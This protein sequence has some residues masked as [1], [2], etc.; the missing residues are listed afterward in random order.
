ML[1]SQGQEGWGPGREARHTNTGEKNVFPHSA[2]GPPLQSSAG[3]WLGLQ[4]LPS[5]FPTGLQAQRPVSV[6]AFPSP[7]PLGVGV[8][9]RGWPGSPSQASCYRTFR[10]QH[11]IPS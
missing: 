6:G 5:G 1:A 10:L 9:V 11:S 8:C 7:S 3:L 2:P 4:R